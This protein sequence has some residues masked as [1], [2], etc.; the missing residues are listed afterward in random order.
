[1]TLI[2][3]Y[4]YLVKK[5]E[6]KYG[7]KTIVLMQVGAFFEVYGLRDNETGI[8]GNSQLIPFSK[9]CDLNIADKKICIGKDGVVM[10]GFSL[11]MIDKY[12]KKMQDIGYTV[13][14]YTQD[15]QSKNTTRS[16]AGIYS[17]GT[18]FSQESQ[19]ITNNISCIW[20]NKINMNKLQLFNNMK[21]AGMNTSEDSVIQVGIGNIDIYTGSAHIFQYQSGYSKSPTTYDELERFISI[22]QPMETIIIGNVSYKEIDDAINFSGLQSKKIHR[23]S[24]VEKDN[25]RELTEFA[26]KCEK[27][28]YQKEIIERFYS[29]DKY[30]SISFDMY[31]NEIASRAFCFLLDFVNQ[32]D[33]SLVTRLNELSFSKTDGKLQL[34]NHSL[35]QLNIIDNSQYDGKYSS[36]LKMLNNA[37]TP[38]GKRQFALDLVNPTTNISHLNNEYDITDH[39]IKTIDEKQNNDIYKYLG[40]IKDISKLHRQLFLKKVSP[41]QLYQLH[42]DMINTKAI[43]AILV[44]DCILT[45]YMMHRINEG[46]YK[47]TIID[48]IMESTN[49]ISNFLTEKLDIDKCKNID[50]CQVFDIN[51]IKIGV[52]QELDEKHKMLLE[53]ND[54]IEAIRLE[55]NTKMSK[56]EDKKDIVEYFK[57][58]ETEKGGFGLIGTKRRC[59]LF[60]KYVED[61]PQDLK[62]SFTSSF[63]GIHHRKLIHLKKD[64]L[65]LTTQNTSNDYIN[66][67]QIQQL[68]NE[69]SSLKTQMKEMITRV[70]I[71]EII[72]KL[73]DYQKDFDLCVRYITI[74]DVLMN[75]MNI[76]KKYNYCKPEIDASTQTK[77]F[78]KARGLRHCL[79]ENIQTDELYVA[80]DIILGASWNYDT[81]SQDGVLLYGTNA[82]GKTSF[83]R[84]IGIAIVMAQAGLY[85]PCASFIYYPYT[86]LF[87]RI[88]GND[89]LFKGLSTF[90]VEM[91]ELRTILRLADENSLILGDE[92]CSGTESISAQSIFVAGVQQLTAKE[93]SFIFATHLHEIVN[94]SEIQELQT[95]SLKHMEVVYNKEEDLLVYDRKLKD[96]PGIN[97]YGLEVCRSLNLPDD[98]LEMANKLRIK[99]HPETGSLFS[100]KESR[101]N[102]QKIVSVCEICKKAPAKEVHHLQ[103]QQYANDNGFISKNGNT[104]HKNNAAN[105]VSI[106][107]N[108]HNTIHKQKKQHK[109]VKTSKGTILEEI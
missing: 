63:D 65:T 31:E 1:M 83:I 43:F 8:I 92:L 3:D 37:V 76:A 42:K 93:S 23:V 9:D 88:L 98:F 44:D 45:Q 97:M 16:L 64:L 6:N 82:V 20:I 4:F 70:Y 24:L 35:S 94:F 67:P 100:M 89:N 14:V 33:P 86:C 7:T 102:S 27:Q 62:I 17:P 103:H 15:E 41:K 18:F 59:K 96:G 12:L 26:F 69:V 30:D 51:F 49:N 10:A 78:V 109:K 47:V 58:H 90:A 79:I 50:V 28:T 19:K 39:I 57:V 38:M 105:L 107:E 61:N 104:F 72:I 56:Y 46:S 54:L 21:I 91:S 75:K 101:Y 77:S 13:V 108:C 40:D 66:T 95:L 84:S 85:V 22:H 106:C 11:Y 2:S 73:Q 80:N 71:E 34:A 60:K 99:Y 52:N 48:E 25:E 53:K 55:L 5:Y 74:I 29:N 32:H 68:C 87:T 81:P 36:V